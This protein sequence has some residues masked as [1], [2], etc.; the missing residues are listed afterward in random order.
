MRIYGCIY[1]GLC[2]HTLLRLCR[3][4]LQ[5][6][7]AVHL[8][9]WPLELLAVCKIGSFWRILN[10]KLCS[11]C[12]LIKC[13]SAHRRLQGLNQCW[14]FG[15]LWSTAR[16]AAKI[17]SEEPCT[18]S[19]SYIR[20]ALIAFML[21]CF[22]YNKYLLKL[23]LLLILHFWWHILISFHFH[24]LHTTLLPF[25]SYIN[26]SLGI[27]TH[28]FSLL[29]LETNQW[30]EQVLRFQFYLCCLNIIYQFPF[31]LFILPGRF[32]LILLCL[33]NAHPP[34]KWGGM[35]MGKLLAYKLVF[36]PWLTFLTHFSIA[37][38]QKFSGNIITRTL[39]GLLMELN[40]L[41]ISVK[42]KHNKDIIQ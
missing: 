39:S 3:E 31:S 7:S 25:S 18:T 30:S 13:I 23:A 40:T 24:L 5:L 19:D 27:I 8:P 26:Q 22:C 33:W 36:F 29:L 2:L 42:Q 35:K 28:I 15:Q 38:V 4:F 21:S 41:H 12:V 34:V 16:G 10:Q 14:S 6:Y 1:I 20:Q 9:V 37:S 32:S 11:C 17:W